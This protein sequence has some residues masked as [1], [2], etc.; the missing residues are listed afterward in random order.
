[1]VIASTYVVM[2]KV[3]DNFNGNFFDPRDS[4]YE[5]IIIDIEFDILILIRNN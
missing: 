3:L 5:C 2:L 1:M 4:N